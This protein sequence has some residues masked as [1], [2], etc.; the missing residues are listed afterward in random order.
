MKC[1]RCGVE[2]PEGKN[3]CGDC[4]WPLSGNVGPSHVDSGRA[5]VKY[6][7]PNS[8]F[9]MS[10]IHMTK[11]QFWIRLWIAIP[12]FGIAATMLAI[13]INLFAGILS[14]FLFALLE[15]TIWRI[16]RRNAGW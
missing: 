13:G 8:L 9:W 16:G 4:G 11:R 5:Y 12:M 14:V 2:N 3:F 10:T 15:Y 7:S 1:P 6:G